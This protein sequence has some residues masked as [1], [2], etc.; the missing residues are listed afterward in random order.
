MAIRLKVL[1][2]GLLALAALGSAAQTAAGGD[3][4][5][6]RPIRLVLGHSPGGN[7]DTFARALVKPLAERLG[8]PVIIDNKPGANQII[9]AEIAAR[10]QPDGYTIYLASQTSLVLNVGAQKKLPYDPVRDFAP[11]SLLYTIPLYLVVHPEVPAHSVKDLVALARAKPGQINFSSVGTGSSVHLAGEMF[12]SMAGID[13]VH[14][15]YRGS[16]E[17]LV[18][19]L[20]GRVQIMF[21]GG[22]SALPRVREGKLR[23]LGMTGSE[24]SPSFPDI[25]TI[26]EAG[27]PGYAALFW[28]GVVAPAGT[29]A[30]IV[31][32]LSAEIGA[33]LNDPVFKGVFAAQGVDPVSST[34]E[35]FSRLIREDLPK[36]TGIMKQAGIEPN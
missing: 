7:A 19:L 33:I 25:P 1:L 8:Q 36:W 18:D 24:R 10:A 14:V 27:L 23:V 35:Q 31:D 6:S 13:M 16:S 9:A 15:P 30:A 29:P 5:P 3:N 28:F 17:A 21:D 34:P 2:F 11:V 22:V 20:A 26:A 4:W 12:K 32:R